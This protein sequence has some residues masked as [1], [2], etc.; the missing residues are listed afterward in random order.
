MRK[1]KKFL[2]GIKLILVFGLVVSLITLFSC[3]RKITEPPEEVQ[4]RV[5]SVNVS[6]Q[7]IEEGQ[8][9]TVEAWVTDQNG[10]AIAGVEV[11][12]YISP[13][14]LGWFSP[15]YAL[16]DSAGKASTQFH[17]FYWGLASIEAK[18]G[19][20][21]KSTQL[22][23]QEKI[24]GGTDLINIQ[25][26]PSTLIADGVSSAD[27]TITVTD[28]I[29]NPVE[30]GTVVKL[31]AGEKFVDIDMDGYFT[32]FVDSLVYDANDNGRWDP[33]GMISST[34]T[35][36][37]GVAQATYTSGVYSGQVYLK[38]TVEKETKIT[39]GEKTLQLT[40]NTAVSSISLTSQEI[41]IQVRGTGGIES[42]MIIATAYDEFG[43]RVPGG[44]S[45]D[46]VI[47]EGPQGG[48][49]ISGVGYGP[50][51]AATNAIGEANVTLNSGIIS[52]TVKMKA[53]VGS[54]ES[55]VT[56]VTINAGPPAYMSLGAEPLNIRGW[57]YVNVI[58]DIVAMVNDIYGN[59][60][61][62]NTS[63]YF[64]TEEGM[65][66]A[67]SET[68][69]GLAKSTY[70]SGDPRNDGIALIYGSTSGGTVADTLGLIVSGPPY[71][72]DFLAYPT[73]IL[74][75]GKDKGDVLVRVLDLNQNLVVGG[76]P[77]EM[78]TNFGLIASGFTE[79]GICASLFETEL[80]SAVL[81]M[82][83]SPVSPDDGIGALATVEAR[84]GWAANWVTVSFLTGAAY[85]KN[86]GIDMPGEIQYGSSVP[87]EVNIE[88]RYGNPLGGHQLQASSFGLGCSI[89]G[90][91]QTTDAYGVADGF[92]FV[93]TADTTVKSAT[94][95][96]I[97]QDPRGGIVLSK[98]VS[99]K[100]EE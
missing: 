82:D 18:V 85:S 37:S 19:D 93:A 99:L 96:M 63:V 9:S 4:S 75:N 58:S 67:H 49:N 81:D 23:I 73:S 55:Q 25:I 31:V 24:M 36:V 38:A 46:F 98:K 54:V 12:F 57:D 48:E 94:I 64:S 84:S 71:Y 45:I 83:Y 66:D 14:S 79:D 52:G 5:Y 30:D 61:P 86:C 33:M 100:S 53:L 80:I 51:I 44:I 78:E 59:P 17:S 74:A 7:I 22:V 13:D 34:E 70:H 95:T 92:T 77:V 68:V 60:V 8:S 88:D 40:P 6:P 72:V 16:T 28:S 62:D 87:I 39:Q 3:E 20:D 69:G 15:S 21:V 27:V 29:G 97:D 42:S 47:T 35:T 76:T 50:V 32:Q 10:Y 89:I 91:T 1:E 56:K 90:A 26:E 65:V 41:S 11:H 2:T 43:N